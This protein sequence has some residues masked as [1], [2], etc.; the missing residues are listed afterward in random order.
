MSDLYPF[1][2]GP[3]PFRHARLAGMSSTVTTPERSDAPAPPLGRAE[4]PPETAAALD[5]SETE[6]LTPQEFAARADLGWFSHSVLQKAAGANACG[7]KDG[8]RERTRKTIAGQVVVIWEYPM[9]RIKQYLRFGLDGSPPGRRKR[10][11]RQIQ[12]IGDP[13]ADQL[14][15]ITGLKAAQ[16]LHAI[17]QGELEAVLHPT[18]HRI[19][20]L[21]PESARRWINRQAYRNVHV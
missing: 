10:P 13:I 21:D 12:F 2:K 15:A 17:D 3:L 14:A 19:L 1:A 6:W 4:I 18:E 20:F 11:K 16:V 8:R 7:L 9:W 5:A